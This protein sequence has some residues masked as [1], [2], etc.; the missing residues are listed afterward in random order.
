MKVIKIIFTVK[1][2]LSGT[3]KKRTLPN[4][5][6]FLKS[7][8][9]MFLRSSLKLEN[10]QQHTVHTDNISKF[11]KNHHGIQSY[12][13]NDQQHFE[14]AQTYFAKGAKTIR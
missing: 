9:K 4:R 10:T 12:V 1:L 6:R 5:G 13:Y 8:I 7:P 2:I 3:S 14:S 11:F